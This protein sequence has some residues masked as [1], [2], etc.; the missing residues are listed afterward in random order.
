MMAYLFGEKN[1]G[2]VGLFT[3]KEEETKKEM[4]S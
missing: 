4:C 1:H 3:G 2:R